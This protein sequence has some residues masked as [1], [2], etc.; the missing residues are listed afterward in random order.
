[1]PVVTSVDGAAPQSM[2]FQT[3]A[4]VLCQPGG[5]IK[6]HGLGNDFIIVDGHGRVFRPNVKTIV[7]LCNRNV[8]IGADQLLVLEQPLSGDDDIRLRIYNIDG[9]E[10]ETCLNATR[11][12]AWFLLQDMGVEKVRIGTPGGTIEGF[13]A[14]DGIVTLKLP[15]ARF[16]WQAIPLSEARDTLAL[17]LTSGPLTA[18]VAVSL[19]NPHIVCFITDFDNIDVPRWAPALQQSPLL[20]KSANVGVAEILDDCRMKLVVWERPGILTSACGSGACAALVAARRLHLTQSSAM[21]VHMPGGDLTVREDSDGTLHLSG[22]VEVAF[23]G[24]LPQ[25][26]R[27]H[28][29]EA[30][31]V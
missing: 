2:I 9:H 15:A 22:P 10:A 26:L 12:V 13:F 4:E 1:M 25:S 19:G 17:G 31:K 7:T 14:G 5:F 21:L 24:F 3:L 20:P 30:T 28:Q 27:D 8:G 6:I 11:C 23:W 29:S 18:Q 16:D